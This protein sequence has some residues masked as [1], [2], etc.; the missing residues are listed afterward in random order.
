MLNT[1][2]HNAEI[3]SAEVQI[4]EMTTERWNYPSAPKQQVQTFSGK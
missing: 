2:M 3:A 4:A 1:L